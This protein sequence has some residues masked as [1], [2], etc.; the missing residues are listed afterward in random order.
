[1]N[2]GAFSKK[3][4]GM[5]K[6]ED[7][8]VRDVLSVLPSTPIYEAM[9]LILKH[10]ISGLP[11]VDFDNNLVGIITEKDMLVLLME[12]AIDEN[13]SVDEFMTKEVKSFR[14]EDNI[15]DICEFFI[16]RPIR[17][18]PIVDGRKLVGIVSRSDIVKLILR[19]RNQL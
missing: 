2:K 19:L 6:V 18:V 1:M 8:M 9:K 16:E 3:G 5:F 7:V 11:V 13:Q 10:R 12:K 15:L 4:G 17:R 14:K